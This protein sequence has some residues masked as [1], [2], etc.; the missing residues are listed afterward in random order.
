MQGSLFFGLLVFFSICGLRRLV[1]K[2]VAAAILAAL[3]LL[4]ANGGVFTSPNWKVSAAIY[5]GMY[6]VLVFILL[7]LGLV[8]T[9]A[10]AFFIDSINL[11]TLGW[12]WKTWYA[13]AGLATFFLLL[14]IAIFAFWRSL[15]SRE[16][17]SAA[18]NP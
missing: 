14:G 10:A 6:S 9:I 15:G 18:A 2:D 3:L 17:F 8:A 11:I 4:F 5:I 13:P 16:L 12:D 7:R 1:R